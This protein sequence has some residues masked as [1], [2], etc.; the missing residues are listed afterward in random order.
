MEPPKESLERLTTREFLLVQA[1]RISCDCHQ[2]QI[3]DFTLMTAQRCI[4]RKPK[5]VIQF[6]PKQ[7]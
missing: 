1:F 2:D 3:F 7:R 5:N 4:A 6:T